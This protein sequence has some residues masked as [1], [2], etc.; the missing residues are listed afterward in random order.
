MEAVQD[1]PR[2]V[3]FKQLIVAVIWGGTW[4]AGRWV[5]A[6]V[7]PLAA[8]GWRFLLGS[9]TLGL[10]VARVEGRLPLLPR[11]EW[12]R[13]L[14]LGMCGVFAY[15]LCFFYGL[16]RLEAGRGALVVALNPVAVALAAWAF[17]GETL[18][19]RRVL[20]VGVALLG[21]LTVI[22]HGNPSA[23]LRGQIGRGELAILGCVVAWAAYT[24]IGRR[25][26][27]TLSPLAMTFYA[28]VI[29]GAMLIALGV[30]DGA[31]RGWPA[32]SLRAW[33]C[34]AYLGILGSGFSYV[35]YADGVKA[36]GATRAAAFI[37]LV[38]VCAVLFGALLLGERLSGMTLAGGGLVLAG[39][40][41]TVRRFRAG[42]RKG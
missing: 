24:L 34:L 18:S 33:L 3:L 37:N 38:P 19:A 29:G 35:W 15:N 30:A 39:V 10:L 1:H 26:T 23:L 41:I 13:V 25:V 28:S 32:F 20:G 31:L 14:L 27:F 2:R 40:T 7:P 22:G 21:C 11:Q 9:L 4:I 16:Q 42:Q 12:G 8:A 6:E 36:L 17:G 5:A